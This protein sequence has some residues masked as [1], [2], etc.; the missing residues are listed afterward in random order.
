MFDSSEVSK[1]EKDEVSERNKHTS[2]TV[3]DARDR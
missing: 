1:D 3:S 2:A